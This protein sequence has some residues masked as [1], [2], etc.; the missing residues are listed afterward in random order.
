MPAC[1]SAG[2][3]GPD[4]IGAAA[5]D[6]A[7]PGGVVYTVLGEFRRA[8]GGIL[9]SMPHTPGMR[10]ACAEEPRGTLPTGGVS[11]KEESA[12]DR[13]ACAEAVHDATPGCSFPLKVGAHPALVRLV[14]PHSPGMF[15]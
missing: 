2:T 9:R 10:P 12:R 15:T 11:P 13:R 14:K 6:T 3:S 4:T 7:E 1:F 8:V 5:L